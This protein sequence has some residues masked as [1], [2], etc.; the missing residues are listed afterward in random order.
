MTTL[1]EKQHG[2]HEMRQSRRKRIICSQHMKLE[3]FHHYRITTACF[4]FQ[5]IDKNIQMFINALQN[6]KLFQHGIGQKNGGHHF[7]NGFI[8]NIFFNSYTLPQ[9][10]GVGYMLSQMFQI[11]FPEG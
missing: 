9:F 8:I 3:F 6:I 2:N 1:N 10:K 5:K 11:F 4:C 7:Y